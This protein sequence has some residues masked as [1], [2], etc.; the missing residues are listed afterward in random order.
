[1]DRARLLLIAVL[2]ALVPIL[3]AS[4]HAEARSP[5]QPAAET[6]IATVRA[7]ATIDLRHA[8]GRP[9]TQLQAGAYAIEVHDETASHNFHLSGPGVDQSTQVSWT[10][11]VTWN[12]TFSSGTYNFQC[13]PHRDFMNGSFNVGSGPPPPAPPPPP[14]GQLVLTGFVGP[15]YDIGLRDAQGNDVNGR[16]IPAGSYRIEI[17]DYSQIHNFELKG[18][19][20]D[21]ETEEEWTGHVTWHATFRPGEEVEYECDPHHNFMYGSFRVGSAPGPPPPPPPPPAPPPPPPG[22]PPPAGGTLYATVRANATIDLRHADGSQVTQV[23]PGAY[24]IQVADETASHNF[25]LSGPGVDRSTDVSWSGA[26]S[27][28]VTLSAGTY[29]FQCDPHNDFMRG[30]FTVASGPAPPPAPPPPPPPPP[31]PAPPAAP[32]LLI[33]TVRSNYTIDV[34]T[35]SGQKVD[36]VKPGPYTIEVR[37]QSNEHNFRLQGSGV[38]KTTTVGFVGTQKWSVTLS[39]GTYRYQCDPHATMM[40]G[41]LTVTAAKK[42]KV[43]NFRVRRS[44]RRAVVT[45]KVDR[46]VKARI[47]LL[48]RSRAV[49]V[50]SGRLRAGQNVKR[51]R[52]RKAGRHV[53]RLTVIENGSRRSF[54]RSVRL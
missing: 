31:P 22:P 12:V 8:D 25:H 26:V 45:V 2:A 29:T 46:V 7:N 33:A 10:G 11:T 19:D 54:S 14:P 4:L 52:A 53:V 15:G 47:Q 32:G 9:V 37:D 3:P 48:R 41:A 42:T 50:F 13:D 21:E 30:S 49:S 24:T 28:A 43:S 34:K 6:L 38:S 17:Y 18:D 40:K 44:A 36:T 35:P 16:V 51:L 5:Q 20:F 39:P 27:W 1:M 23:A